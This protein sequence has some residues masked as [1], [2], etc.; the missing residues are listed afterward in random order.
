MAGQK[1]QAVIVFYGKEIDEVVE[2]ETENMSDSKLSG[3][4]AGI[5]DKL[6]SM[7]SKI[8]SDSLGNLLSGLQTSSEDGEVF[9]LQFNPEE[10]TIRAHGRKSKEQ[11]GIDVRHRKADYGILGVQVIVTI[12]ILFDSTLEDRSLTKK[13]K[14]VREKVEEFLNAV[15]NPYLRKIC[16]SWGNLSYEGQLYGVTADYEMF[17]REGMPIRAKVILQLLCRDGEGSSYWDSLCKQLIG[18]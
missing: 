17:D 5:T 11:M 18:E 1:E 4:L 10:L 14:G 15:K 3:G 12:P 9:P 6:K 13:E 2:K 7:S 8:V 16:F